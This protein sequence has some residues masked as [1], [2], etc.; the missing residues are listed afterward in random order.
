MYGQLCPAIS[1]VP[2]A[3]LQEANMN[4]DIAHCSLNLICYSRSPNWRS[5]GQVE[6]RTV[7]RFNWRNCSR[8]P[9]SARILIRRLLLSFAV[10]L[11]LDQYIATNREKVFRPLRLFSLGSV[12]PRNYYQSCF[13]N[14]LLFPFFWHS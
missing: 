3:V 9:E 12:N 5:N 11:F 1:F 2:F 8:C 13:F 4:V 14:S 10:C 6:E 7:T